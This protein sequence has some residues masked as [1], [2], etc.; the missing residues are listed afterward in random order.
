ML[1]SCGSTA[2]VRGAES[3]FVVRRSSN[4]R[5]ETRAVSSIA[6]GFFATSVLKPLRERRS[7]S[8]S[9]SV[10][11]GGRARLIDHQSEFAD[12]FA[13]RDHAIEMEIAVARQA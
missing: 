8:E 2:N 1:S 12:R 5:T 3:C 13:G 7:N 6:S 9:R 10:A 11:H 4:R